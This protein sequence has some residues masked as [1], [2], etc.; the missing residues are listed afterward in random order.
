MGSTIAAITQRN[1]RPLPS[2]AL[3]L[4]L[5]CRLSLQNDASRY[6]PAAPFSSKK[7]W[8]RPAMIASAAASLLIPLALT[9]G[10]DSQ[11]PAPSFHHEVRAFVTGYNTVAGQTD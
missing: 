3:F 1:S 8:K 5:C 4:T 2:I 6:G 11:S 10:F 7:T 9:A